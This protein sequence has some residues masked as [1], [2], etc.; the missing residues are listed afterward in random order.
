MQDFNRTLVNNMKRF[1]TSVNLNSK[2]FW[3]ESRW[4]NRAFEGEMARIWAKEYKVFVKFG[5]KSIQG[6]ILEN[7][8]LVELLQQIMKKY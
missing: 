8:V 4:I 3:R 6:N 2:S 1:R 7:S 5:E